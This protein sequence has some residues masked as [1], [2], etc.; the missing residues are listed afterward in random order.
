MATNEGKTE[1]SGM[2]ESFYA[3]ANVPLN[4]NGELS[5][6][7]AEVFGIMLRETQACS[8]AFTWIPTPPGG[9]ATIAWLARQLGRGVF[10]HYRSELSFSCVRSAIYKWGREL[11]MA[12][13]G[14]TAGSLPAWV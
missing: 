4:W 8:R 14:L 6:R 9:R 12:S 1:V 13:L 11:A 2:I 10:N 5:D 3:F 7:V